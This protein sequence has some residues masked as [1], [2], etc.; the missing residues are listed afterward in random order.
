MFEEFITVFSYSKRT[1]LALALGVGFFCAI[2]M[3]GHYFTNQVVLSGTLA[4][5]NETIKELLMDKYDKV[6]W[7]A[8]VVFIVQAFKC[9]RK[10]KTRLFR[11]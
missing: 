10:D 2:L 3:L 8:L 11:T 7:G 9:Y 6:A 1:Q 4:P 5:L